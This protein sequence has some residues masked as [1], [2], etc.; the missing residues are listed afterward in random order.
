MSNDKDSDNKMHDADLEKVVTCHNGEVEQTIGQPGTKRDIKS[1]HA[2]M[3]AIGGAIGTSLFVG[4]GQA[5]AVG[6]PGYLLICYCLI[7]LMVYAVITAIIEVGTYLPVPGASMA[8]YA[9]RVISPSVGFALGW[10]Y[11]YSFGI[12]VAYEITAAAI[13]IDYWPSSIHTAVWITIMIIVIIGLNLSPVGVYAETE[14][15]FAGIKVIMIIGLLVLSLVLMLGGGPT[16]DRLGFRFWSDPGAF[17]TLYVGGSGGYFTAFLYVW[18]YCGISFFFGPEMVISMVG[19]VAIGATCIS[20]SEGLISGQ[21]NANAS[22]W[23][24]AIR[25]ASIPI[26]PSI[27]NAGILTS[28]AEVEAEAENW[29]QA[30]MIKNEQK[31]EKG[32]TWWKK[33]R[34]C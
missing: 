5:L 30:Q 19:A 21:G 8:Y 24:I 29:N 3:I 34:L 20:T 14:F 2:Q 13:I 28:L 18:L 9:T 22:P 7:S 25:N 31:G 33:I 26:L 16:H 23:V 15:W 27:I 1:R 6:G 11:F 32:N 10:L 4:S 12:I 17:N